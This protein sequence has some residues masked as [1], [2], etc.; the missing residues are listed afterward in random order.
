M[1]Y[2]TL[3][4]TMLDDARYGKLTATPCQRVTDMYI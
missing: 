3:A 2:Y 1:A 4:M